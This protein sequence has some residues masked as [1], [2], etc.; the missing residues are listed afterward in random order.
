MAK[1]TLNWDC[2]AFDALD[3]SLLYQILQLRQ[4]VFV[5]EQECLYEDLDQLDQ[6]SFHL[7]CRRGDELLAYLRAVPP[8]LSY[9]Q[10]SV[11][12][13]VVSP[14]ARGL[15]L[16]R[17]LVQRGIDFNR[18]QW[19]GAGI[20]IGAQAHLEKFYL[21]CGFETVSPV[22]DEDGIPHLKML[23]KA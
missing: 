19:P 7:F 17:E 1:P 2:L 10:S 11:G 8:E 6:A 21:S 13:I 18:R 22:Y 20:K 12:R 3:N 16:G 9:E 4:K 23:L 15:Q 14:P 5:I